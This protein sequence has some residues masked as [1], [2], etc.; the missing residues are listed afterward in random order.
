MSAS[1]AFSASLQIRRFV[2]PDLS[3]MGIWLVKRLREKQR[4][5][6]DGDLVNMLRGIC[7]GGSSEYWFMRTDHAV[8][9][10]SVGREPMRARPIVSEWFVLVESPEHVDEGVAL[11]RGMKDWALAMQSC[12]LRIG[13]HSDVPLEGWKLAI[14]KVFERGQY[15]TVM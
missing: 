9:L 13:T 15:F 12:E 4:D 14:G 7:V 1:V 5:A 2:L 8:A 10:A 11:Y 6:K 3:A